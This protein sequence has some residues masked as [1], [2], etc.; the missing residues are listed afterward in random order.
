VCRSDQVYRLFNQKQ[1][2]PKRVHRYT[3]VLF[4]FQTVFGEKLVTDFMFESDYEPHL[5]S[6]SQLKYKILIKNKKL[7]PLESDGSRSRTNNSIARSSQA[8][9]H[10]SNIGP[11]RSSSTSAGTTINDDIITV[12]EEEDD[13]DNYE[14]DEEDDDE[15]EIEYKSNDAFYLINIPF[16]ELDFM[17]T[18]FFIFRN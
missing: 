12:V 14:D 16:L 4:F 5:P 6:P 9:S 1:L 18:I 2:L 8:V 15:D 10:H 17:V 11:H 13:E 3:N 7:A